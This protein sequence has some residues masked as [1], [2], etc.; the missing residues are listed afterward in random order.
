MS[1]AGEGLT[2]PI[3]YLRM[4]QMQAN[5]VARTKPASFQREN[6]RVC[7]LQYFAQV[8]GFIDQDILTVIHDAGC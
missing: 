8:V 1:A 6:W 3:L 5:P 4:A 7:Y 2:E